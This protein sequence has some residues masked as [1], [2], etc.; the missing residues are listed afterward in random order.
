M[1]AL[2]SPRFRWVH[3]WV[4]RKWGYL[5]HLLRKPDAHPCKRIFFSCEGRQAV[6]RPWNSFVRW[7]RKTVGQALGLPSSLW[8]HV[9]RCRRLQTTERA[10]KTVWVWCSKPMTSRLCTC[11]R[12]CGLT[13]ELLSN[14]RLHGFSLPGS[15]G[16]L[17]DSASPGWIDQRGCRSSLC[18]EPFM[19]QSWI[20]VVTCVCRGPRCH[21]CV[22]Y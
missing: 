8:P 9:N 14:T 20:S 3:L 17:V 12:R 13:R 18:Q 2:A 21:W 6:G 4:A 5:G 1:L 10:G 16:M 15:R 22:K 11:M 7:A 19:R